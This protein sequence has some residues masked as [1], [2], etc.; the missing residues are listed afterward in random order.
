[1]K[2]GGVFPRRQ[3]SAGPWGSSGPG[4]PAGFKKGHRNRKNP[5]ENQ[6]FLAF[7]AIRIPL[8][9]GPADGELLAN[10]RKVRGGYSRAGRISDSGRPAGFSARSYTS[11]G[12]FW[13]PFLTKILK[14]RLVL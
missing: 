5:K 4:R 12:P 8:E 1:M 7:L 13:D 11:L 14:E 6:R 9:P 2:V 10:L 3:R